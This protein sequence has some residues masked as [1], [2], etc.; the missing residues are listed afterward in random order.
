MVGGDGMRD[1]LHHHGLAGTRRRHDQAALALAERA[2]QI[3][4]A[5]RVFFLGRIGQFQLQLLVRIKRVRL[6]KLMR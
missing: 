3:D 2:D 6:S 4:D 5:R 1:I